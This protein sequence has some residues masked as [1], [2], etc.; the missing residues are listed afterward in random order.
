MLPSILLFLVLFQTSWA[1]LAK[2]PPLSQQVNTTQADLKTAREVHQFMRD[3]RRNSINLGQVQK[4]KNSS[5]KSFPFSE[6]YPYFELAEK[7]QRGS[8]SAAPFFQ[9]CNDEII[10]FQKIGLP[11]MQERI[12]S[13]LQS[14]CRHSFLTLV[15]KQKIPTPL[16]KQ[17][18]DYLTQH[19]LVFLN[20][21]HQALFYSTLPVFMKNQRMVISQII[22]QQIIQN[23]LNPDPEILT[24]LVVSDA[25]TTYI[26]SKG[27]LDTQAN[28]YFRDQ[29]RE[30]ITETRSA[31]D[32]DQVPAAAKHLEQLF[33]FYSQNKN[34]IHH[35]YAWSNIISLGRRSLYKKQFDTAKLAFG[36]VVSMSDSSQLDE[37]L[38]NYL[39]VDILSKDFTAALKTIQSQNILTE[40]D[41]YG[42]KI[43]FWSA[44]VFDKKGQK[45]SAKAIWAHIIKT[46]P[47]SFYSIMSLREQESK[48]HQNLA[49][50][51]SAG[52]TNRVP[53]TEQ[54]PREILLPIDYQRSLSR[55]SL[56]L[57]LDLD[58]YSFF[59]IDQLFNSYENLQEYKENKMSEDEF[60][61]ILTHKLASF[62]NGKDKFL[63]TF[64]ILNGQVQRQADSLNF[65]TLEYLF[66]QKYIQE[67]IK[68]DPNIDPLIILSLIRQESA[69]NPVARSSAGARGLMQIMPNTGRSLQRNLKVYQ[70]NHPNTNLRLGI[71]YFKRLANKY[72]GNLVLALASYN[73]GQGNVNRWQ[74]D[75]FVFGDDPL[76][77]IELIPFKE[78]RKYVKLIY[79]N[80]FFYNMLQDRSLLDSP[81]NSTLNLSFYEP[82]I[83]R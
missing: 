38:F 58:Q 26:Q 82:A 47:M 75:V 5:R 49:S 60:Y 31:I 63:H 55:L 1:S 19:S 3:L 41:K 78:T 52:Q 24:H 39:W 2:H 66:P 28:K 72:D 70:L 33:A 83:K 57:R 8:S 34:Y 18:L 16:D 25:M 10:K 7:I 12:L 54:L 51:V 73:A 53:S 22:E 37:A 76:I 74:D 42:S 80:I 15:K 14:Y 32:K 77:Q 29:I 50:L 27:E 64:R 69:F 71:K 59:E 56:W 30:M 13:D 44:Y 46:D 36:Y 62:F 9:V 48:E 6:I 79:R 40:L 45:A 68:I 17:G 43:K 4:L 20:G 61:D 67:I 65:Q 35:N 23:A 81:F 11:P 21:E